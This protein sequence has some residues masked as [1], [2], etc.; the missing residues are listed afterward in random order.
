[1]YLSVWIKRF[2]TFFV[3]GALATAAWS[4]DA[5]LYGK[6]DPAARAGG[7]LTIGS[8][9]EPPALDPYHQAADA[10]IRVTVLAYQGLFYE[11]ATGEAIPLLAES[12]TQSADGLSYTFNLRRGVKFHTGQTMTSADVKYSY[13]YMRDPKNGSPGAG[14]LSTIESISAPE[15]NG[16]LCLI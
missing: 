2:S 10:R 11:S 9:T 8:L 3:A 7:K 12:Y 4:Q 1:M 6:S 14:D 5:G 16:Q 15:T 13:D